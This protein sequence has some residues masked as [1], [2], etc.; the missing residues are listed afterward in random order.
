MQSLPAH[1]ALSAP[2]DADPHCKTRTWRLVL[3][4]FRDMS[5]A[6]VATSVTARRHHTPDKAQLRVRNKLQLSPRQQRCNGR[7][8]LHV[9]S[10][11]WRGDAHC[12]QSSKTGEV[13][14][15]KRH[16]QKMLLLAE[17]HSHHWTETLH[18]ASCHS[19]T[20]WLSQSCNQGRGCLLRA[21]V[22]ATPST[23]AAQQS[24]TACKQNSVCS[25]IQRPFIRK[26]S[27]RVALPTMRVPPCGESIHLKQTSPQKIY[28]G[29]RVALPTGAAAVPPVNQQPENP[30]T[31]PPTHRGC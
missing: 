26:G 22:F 24:S 21:S 28:A 1:V 8:H 17:D 7:S 31:H 29:D 4:C 12:Q 5:P 19:P 20:R 6:R 27:T 3:N 10:A 11:V 25:R 13:H 14:A 23:P 2:L 16:H 15:G 30:P 9:H 18:S